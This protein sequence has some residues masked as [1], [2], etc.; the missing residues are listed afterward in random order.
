MKVKGTPHTVLGLLALCALLSGCCRP[1]RLASVS[2]PLVPQQRDWW[3]WAATTEMISI[4]Y[5]HRVN[6]CDSANH[7]HGSPPNCCMGCTGQCDCWGSGWGASITDLQSNWR[8][9]RFDFTYVA[10]SLS[11]DQLRSTVSTSANCARSPIQAVW[12]WTGG[13][14]HVVTIYGY[15]EAGGQRYVSY[16]NPWPPDCGRGAT[17]TCSPQAGGDDAVITYAAFLSDGT[18]T[19]GNSFHSFRFVGP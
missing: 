7:I 9:W 15:A 14:G 10:A 3:C 8:H 13:G 12:W 1:P 19:W 2:V 4:Y 16:M 17:G 6:Q 18:H 11:W 5:G